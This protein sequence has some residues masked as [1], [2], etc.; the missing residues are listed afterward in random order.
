MG[1]IRANPSFVLPFAVC[2]LI[3][4]S[5]SHA[6]SPSPQ[7]KVIIDAVKFDEG[8]HLSAE[9]LGNEITALQHRE[10]AED[11]GKWVGRLEAAALHALPDAESHPDY[12][13]QGARADWQPI[14]RDSTGL[15]VSVTIGFVETPGSLY[16]DRLTSIR[17]VDE[18][19]PTRSTLFPTGEMRELIPFRDGELVS[20]EKI[21]T[22][23][24]ALK[25]LYSSKGYID[26]AVTPLLSED[27]AHKTFSLV[28][29]LNEGRQYR[30]GTVEVVG[31]DASQEDT[32]KAKLKSGDTFNDD[33]LEDFYRDN[34][35]SR[36]PQNVR[37]TRHSSEGVVDISFDFR[38][39]PKP[40]SQN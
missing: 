39:L 31:L 15:H 37:F 32:L 9:V 24:D 35:I 20:N 25:Q 21:G 6:Q 36:G 28:I 34:R 14:S 16:R 17:F 7:T 1:L 11:S 13:I 33:F 29:Q 10:F 22:G 23:L 30:V 38:S 2:V 4:P 12:S 19:D 40:Q 5:F 8:A 3:W 18:V 26:A 27:D